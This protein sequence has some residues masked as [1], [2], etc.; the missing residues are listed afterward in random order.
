MRFFQRVFYTKPFL[1]YF[2][3]FYYFLGNPANLANNGISNKS[4]ITLIP[5]RYYTY[6]TCY[7]TYPTCY[8]FSI[9]RVITKYFNISIFYFSGRIITSKPPLFTSLLQKYLTYYFF[10]VRIITAKKRGKKMKKPEVVQKNDFVREVVFSNKLDVNDIKILKAI[11][12]QV[13][14]NDTLFDDFYTIDYNLLDLVGI[15]KD[16][17]FERVRKTLKNLANTYIKLTEEQR[18]IAKDK[19]LKMFKGERELGII[20]N[21]FYYP[22]HQSKIVI[23]LTPLL[24]DFLLNLEDN[25]VKYR[26]ENLAKL[27]NTKDI[28]I[29]E[30]FSSWKSKGN[31]VY[32]LEQI[33]EMFDLKTKS[34]KLYGNLKK[35]L[36]SSI[37]RV[38]KNTDIY[39]TFE[40]LDSLKT[41]RTSKN[42]PV[43]YLHFYIKDKN[44]LYN[45]NVKSLVGKMFLD[46]K[47]HKIFIKS[48]KQSKDNPKKFNL[49]LVNLTEVGVA[50]IKDVSKTYIIENISTRLLKA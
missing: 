8:Y 15:S 37:E 26:L 24:K 45:I 46:N 6:P 34:F 43:K 1:F 41:L 36:V 33:K 9:F 7:Y 49:E 14:S 50:K 17:R 42:T 16:H 4:V 18:E 10:L 39:I 11:I 31:V 35:W 12:S 21:D 47:N 2:Y 48:I 19:T 3:Y 29:Y 23:S 32:S 5:L 44:S 13:K 25:F 30:I 22:K 40:E 20:K 27:K 38:N 28:K